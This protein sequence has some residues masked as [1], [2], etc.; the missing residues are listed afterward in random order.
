VP[1]FLRGLWNADVAPGFLKHVIVGVVSSALTIG[2]TV[3]AASSA[4][5][6]Q[7]GRVDQLEA[8]VVEHEAAPGLH[9]TIDAAA[10][11]ADRLARL[12]SNQSSLAEE[13]KELRDDVRELLRRVR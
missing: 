7:G 1:R 4:W 13:V 3:W 8:R 5:T 12:E 9:P 6:R 11:L 2:A 10:A